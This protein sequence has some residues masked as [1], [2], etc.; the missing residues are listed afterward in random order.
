NFHDNLQLWDSAKGKIICPL[1]GHKGAVYSVALSHDGNL[2]LSASL[3]TPTQRSIKLWDVPKNKLIRDHEIL[4][5]KE[6]GLNP[7]EKIDFS[8]DG[9]LIY[10]MGKTFRAWEVESGKLI[11]SF[12]NLGKTGQILAFSPDKRF[13]LTQEFED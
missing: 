4:Y 12:E 13:Y 5:E 6:S 11:Q 1:F 3:D 7:E 10:S 8:R 2:G 9:K